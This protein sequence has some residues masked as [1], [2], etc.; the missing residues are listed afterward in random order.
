[1]LVLGADWDVPTSLDSPV[2]VGKLAHCIRPLV[3]SVITY[4]DRGTSRSRLR[5]LNLTQAPLPQASSS[6]SSWEHSSS[7]A[8]RLRPHD[9]ST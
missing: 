5:L 6:H 8:F 4:L 1:V 3:A 9:Y 2:T 7:T